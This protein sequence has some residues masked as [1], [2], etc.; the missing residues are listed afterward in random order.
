MRGRFVGR[1]RELEVTAW[2]VALARERSAPTAAL[3]LGPPGSGKSRLLR[4]AVATMG[5]IDVLEAVGYEPGRS[6]PLT[7]AQRM[8]DVLAR[9]PQ[10]G[11]R[12]RRAAFGDQTGHAEASA[13][14]LFEAALRCLAELA[15]AI[16]VV[17]DLQWADEVSTSLIDYLVRGAE[18][19]GLPLAT[20]GAGRPGA[21]TGAFGDALRRALPEPERFVELELAPLPEAAAIE[22]VQSIDPDVSPAEAER[23]WLRSAG[24]PFWIEALATAPHALD[25]TLAQRFGRLGTDAAALLQAMALIARPTDRSELAAVLDWP[26]E[27]AGAAL[28]ELA[29]R[30][31]IVEG[32]AAI[33]LAHDL[34]REAAH[35]QVPPTAARRLH[36]R[37]AAHL[38]A[39][40]GDDV[41]ILRE[42]L[43]H[44]RLAEGPVLELALD[45]AASS[46][47]RLLGTSGVRELAR[48]AEAT[49]GGDR[50][51]LLLEER[52]A[53]LASELGDRALEMERW[54]I[55]AERLEPGIR[56][57][58]LLAS[59]TAAYRLGERDASA[60][61]LARAR[62]IGSDDAALAIALDAQEAEMLRWL[63]HR[64]PEARDLT[65]RALSAAERELARAR[66]RG[67]PLERR[68]R[69]AC[70]AAFQAASDLAL[71]EGDEREQAA[72]AQRIVELAGDELERMEA[73]LLLS[74]A[75][76]RSG[77]MEEAAAIDARVRERAERTL[78]PAVAM[79]AGHHLARSLY[80]LARMEEA[81]AA[82]AEAERIA[83]R[84][85]QSG[86]YLSEMRSLRPGI[87]VSTGDW[88]FGIEQLRADIAREPDPHYQ[89]GIQQEI[90]VWLARLG[91]ESDIAEVRQMLNDAHASLA[92]VG[93]PRCGREL[94][95][96]SAETLARIGDPEP[97]R[98][99]MRPHAGATTRHSLEGRLALERAVASLHQAGSD[100]RRAVRALAR[101]SAHLRAA[102][103]LREALWSDLDLATTLAP[104][105][106]DR[107]VA[108]LRS[109]A[110]RAAGGG[111]L[112]D[113]Q[114]A[115]QRLRSLGARPAPPRPRAGPFGLTRREL[116][117]A[118]LVAAGASNPEIAE[119]LFVSR[120]T[121]ERHVSAALAKSQARNRAE[122]ATRLARDD[123]GRTAEMGELPHTE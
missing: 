26:A 111:V 67:R 104:D 95:L 24:S 31:V 77:R 30:G 46:Q 84:I 51:R 88:R 62:A 22:L 83:A 117:V 42:A 121:V 70:L 8:I 43:D 50:R 65:Q 113:L 1:Q 97:A 54:L 12:L 6:V 9:A 38:H 4:E 91:S 78:Y 122:L 41:R 87:T 103:Q 90:A 107:A 16:L 49:D 100:R 35:R 33:Q 39:G 96:R 119:V 17:D 66:E 101:L 58:A 18:A 114:L 109:V 21:M 108:L 37:L 79:R 63:E 45:L 85:G 80:S 123:Q 44:A 40:A 74:S 102:G 110:E 75:F 53:E 3:I 115:R 15:P 27:R 71:Q 99:A 112:T 47:R 82:A 59:A 81:A 7:A 60:H 94:A 10:S 72:F 28:A 120:K 64:L 48:L 14:H 23:I 20:I 55:V 56:S 106:P 86:R 34:I 25:D 118:R 36:A 116:E 13:L 89:L 57:R 19:S 69:A 92:A 5:D 76:R 73:E 68:L 98:R 93:C 11:T 105:D 29:G 32:P 52:L 2:I 61:L